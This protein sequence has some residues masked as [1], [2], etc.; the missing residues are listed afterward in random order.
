MRSKSG[1]VNVLCRVDDDSHED[2]HTTAVRTGW[3]YECPRYDGSW[4]R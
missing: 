3:G 2:P 4:P 1:G